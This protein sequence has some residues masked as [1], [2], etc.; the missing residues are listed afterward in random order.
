MDGRGSVSV[1]CPCPMGRNCS[2]DFRLEQQ[3]S[4][5]EPTRLESTVTRNGHLGHISRRFQVLEGKFCATYGW[6]SFHPLRAHGRY[7]IAQKVT[8]I[9][10]A[11]F[12]DVD[13]ELDVEIQLCFSHFLYYDPLGK[14]TEQSNCAWSRD[15][16]NRELMSGETKVRQMMTHESRHCS[17]IR[18]RIHVTFVYSS[19]L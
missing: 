12:I 18:V 15:A 4:E 8:C 9:T 10:S 14:G 16:E 3:H 5:H 19:K 6:E 1:V 7:V 11:M 13:I 17:L 2:N